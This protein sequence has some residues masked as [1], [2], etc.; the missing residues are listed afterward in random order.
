MDRIKLIIDIYKCAILTV[1]AA[2]LLGIFLRTPIPFTVENLQSS[3]VAPS[4]IPVI[5]IH[6]GSVSVSNTVDVQGTVSLN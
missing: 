3:A 1:I 2:I 6:G 5:R 4:E